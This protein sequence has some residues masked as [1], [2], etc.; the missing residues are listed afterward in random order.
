VEGG[1]ER[2]ADEFAALYAAAGFGLVRIIPTTSDLR[3][4]EGIPA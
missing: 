3:L 1:Q 4:I 2:T